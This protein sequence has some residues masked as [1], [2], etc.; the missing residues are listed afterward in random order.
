MLLSSFPYQASRELL[1]RWSHEATTIDA[2]ADKFRRH[3]LDDFLRSLMENKADARRFIDE[4]KRLFDSE[5]R[6]VRLPLSLR[7]HANPAAVLVQAQSDAD[8]AERHYQTKVRSYTTKN[9]DLNKASAGRQPVRCIERT[10]ETAYNGTFC[11]GLRKGNDN[12]E[13][14]RQVIDKRDHVYRAHND[15]VLALREYNAIDAQHVRKIRNL[16]A[17]YEDVQLLL[18]RQWSVRGISHLR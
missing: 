11:L 1:L 2:N 10:N 15:Y 17:Y 13:L 9:N 7:A 6:K 8:E 16:L 18:N 3:V 4:H 12:R 5:H 14:K